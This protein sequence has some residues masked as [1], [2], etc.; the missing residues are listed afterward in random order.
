MN[1][2]LGWYWPLPGADR[3]SS[4]AGMFGAIR[5]HDIHTGMDIYCDPNQICTPVEDGVVTKIELF[6][7]P[8]ASP[9]SPWWNETYAIH[10]EG[11]SGVVVYGEISPSKKIQVGKKVSVGQTMGQIKTVLKKDKGLPMTMLHIELYK[12]GTTDTV[13]WNLGEPQPESLLD[14]TPYFSKG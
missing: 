12:P 13:V 6:T 2:T 10:V 8:N 5:K 4:Y 1:K 7:G 9:P 14:P 3:Y 11:K